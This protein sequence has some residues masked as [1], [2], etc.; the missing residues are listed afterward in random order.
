[1]YIHTQTCART[2]I[3]T[4]IHIC[5]VLISVLK[6]IVSIE[7]SSQLISHRLFS[8]NDWFFFTVLLLS[9]SNPI[10]L[11]RYPRIFFRL[12]VCAVKSIRKNRAWRQPYRPLEMPITCARAFHKN[13]QFVILAFS[14]RNKTKIVT[15]IDRDRTIRACICT[16]ILQRKIYTIEIIQFL[17]IQLIFTHYYS[18][19]VRLIGMRVFIIINTYVSA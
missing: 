11:V 1:M 5:I 9:L 16:L 2:Y 7:S 3:H 12:Y 10:R 4:H 8:L 18:G 14:T 19:I 13:V 6:L 15:T 17:F